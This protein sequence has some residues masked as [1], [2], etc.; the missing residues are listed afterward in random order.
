YGPIEMQPGT[1]RQLYLQQQ[2]CCVYFVPVRADARFSI[3]P[4]PFASIDATGL[5]T[6][7]STA[8]GGLSFR[9]YADV[10]HGRRIVSDDVNVDTP[11]SNPLRGSWRQ[12][13]EIPCD[14]SPEL[15]VIGQP[16]SLQMRGGNRFEAVWLAFE[17][18]KDYWGLYTFDRV[19]KRV[20]LGLLAANYQPPAFRGEGTYEITGQGSERRLRLKNIWLGRPH[21]DTRPPGC[22]MVFQ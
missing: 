6:V 5:L 11:E 2:Q 21:G 20:T 8:P 19:A 7:D 22:G 9:V 18:Y 15:P 14:G 1:T 13:A 10:E 3:D 12:T 16:L 17:I 4:T